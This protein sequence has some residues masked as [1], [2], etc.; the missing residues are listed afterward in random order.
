M[1]TLLFSSIIFLTAAL[2]QADE[3]Q[4]RESV[5]ELLQVMNASSMVDAIYSQLQPMF[6]NM[7]SE[8]D[9]QA[10]EQ[11]IWDQYYGKIVDVMKDDMGWDKMKGPM[12][13]IYIKNF[14]DAEIQGMLNFYKS[15]IGQATLQKLPVVM[16]ESMLLGQTLAQ[17]MMPK[18]MDL[19]EALKAE[20]TKHREAAEQ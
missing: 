7:A 8:L 2:C 10:D 17:T 5:D 15:E 4:K 9:I 13:D 14:N 3:T 19:S 20:I 11:V 12:T 1:K 18:I 6:K 16:Q